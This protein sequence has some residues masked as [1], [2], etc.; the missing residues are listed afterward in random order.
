MRHGIVRLAVPAMLALASFFAF[1]APASAEYAHPMVNF[2][3]GKE[4]PAASG[5]GSGCRL[6]YQQANKRLYLLADSSVYG[7][8][9]STPGVAT[10]LPGFPFNHGLGSGCGDPGLAVDNSNGSNKNNIYVTPSNQSI[11]GFNSS[12]SPLG[13]PWP[14]NAGGETCGVAVTNNGEVWGGNYG[15]SAVSKFSTGGASIG[16]FA[17]GYRDC[18][19]A[20]DQTNNDLYVANYGGGPVT[21][22]AAPGYA[23]GV[24]FPSGGNPGLAIN[25]SKDRIYIASGA[26]QVLAY[27]TETGDLI[28]TIE[29]G[30]SAS[31]VAV[32][33]EN[34]TVWVT[35]GGVIKE[36]RGVLV[37]K[38]TTG[39]PTANSSVSGSA[40]PDGTG[41]ITECFFEYGAGFASTKSCDQALP[42]TT[43]TAVSA[44][45]PGL[46]GEQANPYRLVL[47]N[48]NGQ[49]RGAVRTITPHNVKGLKTEAATAITR[50]GAELHASFEGDGTPTTYYF[51][52]GETT[53]YDSQ[54][55]TPPGPSIGSPTFPPLTDLAF[56]PTGLEPDTTYHFHVVAENT[57]GISPGQDLTFKTLPAVQ[58]LTTLAAS[59]VGGRTATLNGSYVGDG[60]PTTYYF[61]YG[62]TPAYGTK[63]TITPAATA[64]T[65]P[66]AAAIEGLSLDTEYHYRVVAT[67]SLGT[68]KGS[69][70]TFVTEK[71]VKGW[72]HCRRPTFRST[73]SRSTA[74]TSA[75]ANRPAI[76]SNTGRRSTT[77]RK[78]R[79]SRPAK[80]SGRRRSRS[81][82]TSS[83]GSRPTTSG[84]SPKTPKA[85]P[86]ATT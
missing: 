50:E 79:R 27:N 12:G 20:V 30:G 69:D 32:N 73:A 62:P 37:P 23:A 7:L 5:T 68:T 29:V 51:E 41:N 34:D 25:G 40:D 66:F 61:E 3:F 75:T 48:A 46:L 53:D 31:G 70:Q 21:K 44:T 49:V 80:G 14:V 6:A 57:S 13:A 67:N 86:S 78:P 54:S 11:Y 64:G 36:L 60:D 84:W 10:L 4:G 74:N 24:S 15:S 1:I 65:V 38:A 33:E 19:L 18:K 76:G 28:E 9:V 81:L 2:E 42:I 39:E 35:A 85:R 17:L 63:T 26:S 77:A 59:D 8:D 83:K 58:S 82:P 55:A 52:W 47:G 56:S 45:L 43:P 22:Y 72:R 16:N 71:A